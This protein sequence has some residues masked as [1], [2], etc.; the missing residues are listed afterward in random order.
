MRPLLDD[1]AMI[2]HQNTIAGQHRRKPMGDHQR[3]ALL[4]QIFQRG[5]HKRFAF[6]IERGSRLVQQ[7]QR[8]IAQDRARDGDALAL[9]AGQRDAAFSKPPGIRVM[10][11]VA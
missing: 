2:H 3:G 7:Q 8:R 4:H 5:L 11:S 10:N 1:P 9:A 6:G